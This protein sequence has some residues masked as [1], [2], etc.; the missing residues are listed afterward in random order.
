GF[1]PGNTGDRFHLFH[2]LAR[3]D[4]GVT[5]AAAAE[6][7]QRVGSQSK[8]QGPCMPRDAVWRRRI[9]QPTLCSRSRV[10]HTIG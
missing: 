6:R 3:L 9:P 2:M 5:E 1:Y 4:H 10:Q 7:T 8:A